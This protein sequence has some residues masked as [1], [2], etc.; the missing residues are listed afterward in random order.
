MIVPDANLVVYAHD[1]TSPFHQE[2]RA[3]WED[4]LSG[5]E[6]VGIPWIVVLAF[7]RLVTH[8]TLSENPMP[9]A[10]ARAA[11]D[12]WMKQQHVRLLSPS[13]N[14]FA[15]FF[16]LLEAVDSGGNL[17]TDAMIAALALEHGGS[18]FSNDKDF[19]RLPGVK[20]INP[21]SIS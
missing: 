9:V 13:E 19:D 10:D 2:A 3:W 7:V 12:T 17:S 8:P 11:V 15:I 16:N 4:T 5:L 1:A 6:P 21:L 20:W 14:T 18:V